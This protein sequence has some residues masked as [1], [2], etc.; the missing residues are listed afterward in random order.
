MIPV[1]LALLL[2]A[3]PVSG[4]AQPAEGATAP[5]EAGVAIT[6]S[7]LTGESVPTVPAPGMGTFAVTDVTPKSYAP[8]EGFDVYRGKL[9]SLNI[10]AYV[11]LRYINQLPAIQS[12]TD[13]LGRERQIDTR[14]DFQLHRILLHFKGFLFDE[15]FTHDT[16]AW[17]VNSTN[18]VTLIS[19]LGFKFHK[20]FTL[21]GGI[22]AMPG[23]R[24][25]NYEHPYFLGTDRQ[26][27]D[28]FF[29]PSFTSGIW[30]S[31]EPV[32]RVNYRLMV[33]NSLN[34]VDISAAQITRDMAYGATLWWMPTT[35]EFGPRGGFGDFEMHSQLAT[36]VGVSGTYSREDRFSQTFE[37]PDNTTIKL[38]DS[39]NLFETG[40]LAPDATVRKADF[41]LAAADAALKYRGFFLFVE[42][43]R[44]QL[45]NF[46]VEGP[47]VPA[48][49]IDDTGAM[50]Q[51]AQM[52]V[53]KYWELYAA[54][55]YIW[56]EFND[57]WEVTGGTNVYPYASRHL[58]LNATVI[59]VD[60]SPV[61][62]LFGYFVGGQK[63]PTISIS[64]DFTF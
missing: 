57:A 13:H 24:S 17:A 48:G 46:D 7:T 3:A 53:P 51:A 4:A 31:G 5:S 16:T 8:G 52:V 39:V 22:G 20:G 59:Y 64:T 2:V 30:A 33:G 54:H 29:R 47:P 61:S 58:K 36:R 32:S 55:S 11:L 18:S 45:A 1:V 62:S 49:T 63:G 21:A 28:E 42:G 14:H 50:V 6:G 41:K 44:R 38:S 26:M 60:R 43:Y 23:T 40:A 56:G 35:G 25:L 27:G 9:G 12:F 37:F 15:R 10:S 19:T 34:M